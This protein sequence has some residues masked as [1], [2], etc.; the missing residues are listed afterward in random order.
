MYYGWVQVLALIVEDD[1]SLGRL[2]HQTLITNGYS[3]Q[4]VAPNYDGAMESIAH[5]RPS[6]LIVDINLGDGRDGL[7]LA[8]DAIERFGQFGV[9]VVTGKPTSDVVER[10]SALR[11]CTILVKPVSRKQLLTA[12]EL[13]ATSA[14]DSERSD[15][16]AIAALR[17]IE[18][19]LQ[20]E[21]QGPTPSQPSEPRF[22]GLTRREQQ[23]VDAVIGHGSIASVATEL[24][25]S[26]HT[27]KNHLK[28][29][30]KKLDVHSLAELLALV[31]TRSAD[32]RG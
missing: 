19:V 21:G 29:V 4:R 16:R 22:P 1:R 11:F 5:A 7:E 30:Y 32:Q 17:A 12:V 9:V 14:V 23:V 13:V 31:R 2:M 20:N 8:H 3:V 28:S 24:V 27:V 18:A 26:S 6:V 25:I 10:A 15:S